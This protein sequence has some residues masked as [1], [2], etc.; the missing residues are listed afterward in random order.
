MSRLTTGGSSC[1]GSAGDCNRGPESD[2]MEDN[3]TIKRREGT[4]MSVFTRR[5]VA[6]FAGCALVAFA[7]GCELSAT[8]PSEDEET[9]TADQTS[10]QEDTANEPGF[11]GDFI[12]GDPADAGEEIYRSSWNGGDVRCL[13]ADYDGNGYFMSDVIDETDA[14]DLDGETATAHNFISPRTGL[15]YRFE[16]F[17]EANSSSGLITENPHTVVR[18]GTFRCYWNPV[19][20]L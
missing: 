20:G 12:P 2:H 10:T 11:G 15:H 13:G 3:E 16:G 17:R 4:A 1:W 5:M 19:E 18:H 8:T 6:G 14:L 7:L 9:D